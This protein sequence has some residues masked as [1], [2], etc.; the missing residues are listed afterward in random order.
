M[1]KSE[2][3][4]VHKLPLSYHLSSLYYDKN[5]EL[6]HVHLEECYYGLQK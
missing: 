2:Q 3:I 1:G 4:L 6:K 5:S